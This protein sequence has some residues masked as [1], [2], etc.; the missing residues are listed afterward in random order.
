VGNVTMTV[1]RVEDRR[2]SK[3]MIMIDPKVEETDG[4]EKQK[5]DRQ[6]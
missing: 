5:S 4:D 6:K 2:I 3:I 1:E